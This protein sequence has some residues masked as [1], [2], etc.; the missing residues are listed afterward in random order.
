MVE[1]SN[2]FGIFTPKIGEM[3]QFDGHIFQM[4]WFNHQP[5]KVWKWHQDAAIKNPWR[6]KIF[7]L[8][9]RQ[10]I[11][12]LGS[13][14]CDFQKF[15]GENDLILTSFNWVEFH[16]LQC[17]F[18]LPFLPYSWF[19]GKLSYSNGDSSSTSTIMGG[20]VSRR[21]LCSGKQTVL[22]CLGQFESNWKKLKLYFNQST[23]KV[24]QHQT[25][26]PHVWSNW[27]ILPKWLSVHSGWSFRYETM[28]T[29]VPLNFHT[30]EMIDKIIYTTIY[31]IIKVCI[32]IYM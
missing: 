22:K 3:I 17:S 10:L 9:E 8:I 30:P 20:R 6:C 7:S 19:S 31:W 1:T 14:W 13:R 2:I 27:G 24:W 25:F 21:F 15:L 23:R 4:G 26:F 18:L 11:F 16:Q 32:Y 29:C 12:Q 5:V 28:S